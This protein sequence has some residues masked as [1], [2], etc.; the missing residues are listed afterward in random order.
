MAA[1]RGAVTGNVL[2]RHIAGDMTG[3]AVFSSCA[4]YRYRL[5]RAWD[6]DA[7]AL[8]FV[9]LNP[10]TADEQS[11]D[12]TLRICLRR[13]R[14]GGFGKV[15]VLNLFALRTRWPADLRSAD[16]PIGPG[17]DAA[18]AGGLADL[19]GT[20]DRVV[21]GW[22]NAG[23]LQGRG[24]EVERQLRAAGVALHHLGLTASGAPRHPLYVSLRQPLLPWREA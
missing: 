22:G 24:P 7:P 19:S 9:M 21:C 8:V 18:I 3:L 15:R 12:A 20:A 4:T 16:D 11:L 17:N 10:S 1:A 14:D 23:Q 5:E 6:A 13:A 2:R